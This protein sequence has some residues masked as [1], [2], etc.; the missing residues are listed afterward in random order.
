MK[1]KIK[2]GFGACLAA[3]FCVSANAQQPE[4]EE[5]EE[6]V[7]SGT[8]LARSGYD[9]PTP[10]TVLGLEQIEADAPHN[11]AD[12]VNQLPSVV[13]SST[14]NTSNLSVSSGGAGY[15][16]INL[17][18]LGRTRTLT[19]LNGRRLPGAAND[20]AVDIN[21]I[22]QG[23]IERVEV[24]TGG[25]SAVYGSDALGGVVNLITRK[26]YNGVSVK[27][28][29]SLTSLAGGEKFELDLVAGTSSGKASV[30]TVGHFRRNSE[31]FD[32][33]SNIIS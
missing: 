19:L 26:D 14:P 25:A 30:I 24:V 6:I 5:I 28:K 2:A 12:I 33:L 4:S 13:G 31:V 18:S 7:V 20:N 23:L 21:T 32:I 9:T 10:V 17:R 8:R 3:V 27:A 22:P 11:I 1:I 29:Q 16:G 15:N